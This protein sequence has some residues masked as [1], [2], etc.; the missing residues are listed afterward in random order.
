[1]SKTKLA[2]LIGAW[3][4][5]KQILTKMK[6]NWYSSLSEMSETKLAE[7]IGAPNANET[8]LLNIPM[9]LKTSSFQNA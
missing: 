2:E 5:V 7:L 3:Q 8:K 1:M 4:P 9:R 6:Q